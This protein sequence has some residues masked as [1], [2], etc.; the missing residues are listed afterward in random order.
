LPRGILSE[1]GRDN[2][3]H[4]AFVDLRWINSG[5]LHS[6]TNDDGAELGCAEI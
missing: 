5:A 4:D 2:V 3:A 6:F 1:S